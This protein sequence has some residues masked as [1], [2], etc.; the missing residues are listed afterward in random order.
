MKIL[1]V[2]V[3]TWMMSACSS[4]RPWQNLPMQVEPRA[5][6]SQAEVPERSL[7][8]IVTFSGGGARAAA[9][10][11]GVLDGLRQT[12]VQW[13]GSKKMLLDELDLVS[14][15]SGGS[16]IAAYYA[17]FGKETFPAFEQEF[18]RQN[19]QDSLVSNLANP[20]NLHDLSSPWFGRTHLLA[21]R[22]DE[23][24]KGRTFGDLGSQPRLLISATDLSLGS[25]FEFT[26]SQFA[27]ICSDLAT[28]PLSFA[29]ASS[30]AVP[31]ALSPMTL[32]NHN[33]TCSR[34]L[35]KISPMAQNDY[36]VRLL[37]GNQRSYLNAAE[38]PYIHLVDGGLADNL[39]LRSL[40]DRSR[41]DGGLR[42]TVRS[43][44]KTPIQK[45][46][47]VA[48]NAERAPSDRIDA[49][50][51]VPG[52]LQVLDALLFGSGARATQETLELLNDTAQAWRDELSRAIAQ[53]D[54]FT[55]D[56]KVHV[57]NVNLRDAPESL[58]RNDLLRIPTAFS[59]SQ[60]EVTQLIEAGR[61]ILHASPEYKALLQSLK[62]D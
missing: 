7:T 9:F 59:I 19:F 39:G 54:T 58:R 52:M 32:K 15:V 22:L 21:K 29:V 5:S 53:D 1:L 2:L 6:T 48:V 4:V 18:L 12:P 28:V 30:S 11:Y 56:A 49:S 51:E 26:W 44:S 46:V 20:G 23:L 25:P 43:Q 62:P 17:A 31:L 57:I 47:I 38:R 8:L 33:E 24:Y 10:G 16:I 45:L 3:L 27:L 36:R 37:R 42:S 60:E 40:L 61:H 50:D 14:G 35:K 13:H 41:A 34:D 55:P